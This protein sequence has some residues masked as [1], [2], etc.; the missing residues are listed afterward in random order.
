MITSNLKQTLAETYLGLIDKVLVNDSVLVETFEKEVVDNQVIVQ[1]SILASAD[2]NA[3][4][5]VAIF[6][7][8]TKLAESK[9]YVPVTSD[10]IFKYKAEVM[11]VE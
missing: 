9:L 2:F 8:E 10:T 11:Q 7:G 5:K 4:Q 3:I 1:F 6:N